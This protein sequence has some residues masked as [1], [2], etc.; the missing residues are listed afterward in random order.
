MI[1]L[2]QRGT[3]A[4]RGAGWLF[5]L[6]VVALGISVWSQGPP[7]VS[8]FNPP[9]L[10]AVS[11]AFFLSRLLAIRLPQGDEVYATLVVGLVAL[12][13]SSIWL[14]MTS[15]IVA[16]IVDTAARFRGSTRLTSVYRLIDALRGALILGL[17]SPYQLLLRPLSSGP[18]ADDRVLFACM[19]AGVSY[20]LVD[21]LTIALHQR[22]RSGT[23]F[24][25]AALSLARPLGTV[26]V[27][28]VPMA[29][30]SLRLNATAGEWAFPVALLLTLI[31]QNSFNLYLRIRRAYTETIGALAHAA[32]LDRP[33]DSGHV[34][35]VADLSIAVG[36]RMGLSGKELERLGYAAL[37]HDIGRM[38]PAAEDSDGHAKRGEEI[39]LSIPFLE[40]VAP[41]IAGGDDESPGSR[42]LGWRIVRCCSRYDRLRAERGAQE[43]LDDIA[44]ED[45]IR[46]DDV[47]GSLASVVSGQYG[48][49]G[50]HI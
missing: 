50:V 22:I 2:A 30:V 11:A 20:A 31:L 13:I 24:L 46:Q 4:V 32:E 5:L 17:L 10:L 48:G 15:A 12:A 37:L 29:A 18:F 23:P 35:R 7:R 44:Q 25:R 1:A 3:R 49:S 8:D 45:W 6:V 34:R 9:L 33:H 42:P 36:R 40:H 14:V 27:V 21:V 41:L 43:A 26:Y 47:L 19:L 16:G 38:G 28:H 39:A